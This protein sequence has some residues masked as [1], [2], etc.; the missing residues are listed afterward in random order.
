[1]SEL[2][3]APRRRRRFPVLFI[4]MMAVLVV[5]AAVGVFV[6]KYV[7]GGAERTT[8]ATK[9]H[10]EA[11]ARLEVDG[12]AGGV[13]VVAASGDETV[14]T[15]TLR[16]HGDHRPDEVHE[17]DGDTLRL[18]DDGCRRAFD[19]AGDCSVEWRIELPADAEVDI[20]VDSGRITTT[21]IEGAQQLHTDSGGIEVTEPGGKLTVTGDSGRLAARELPGTEVDAQ[22]DSG[23]I[24]LSFV[25]VPDL[26]TARTDSGEVRVL[27]P[28]GSGGY[29]VHAESGVGSSDVA[30][31][32]DPDSGHRI[33]VATDS[34]R[35]TVDY[36]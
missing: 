14:V 3:Q 13:E 20:S 26:V 32:A 33:D 34:G 7:I 30:V 10:T 9:T 27:V 35:I 19:L 15:T 2:D 16:W 21:G 22:L 31:D 25:E 12:D 11:V 18:T 28:T 29:D 1:M 4:V 36:A 17:L 23:A 5:I 6:W 8:T 24:E